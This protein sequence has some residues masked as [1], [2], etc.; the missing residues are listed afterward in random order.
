MKR[1]PDSELELMLII[2]ES[3][4][5]M[6]RSDIEER[7][8]NERKLSKTTINSF[9]TRLEQKGFIKSEKV[10]RAN[11]YR[12]LIQE[13][14]YLEQESHTILEKLYGNSIKNFVAALYQGKKMDDS[15]VEE[16]RQYIDE[17][18]SKK[19]E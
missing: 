1:L 14:D 16:L 17:L 6:T 7:L 19:G 3:L 18:D 10:G 2:W 15:Q 4:E 9:L 13:K 8:G 5:P 12:A 11:C